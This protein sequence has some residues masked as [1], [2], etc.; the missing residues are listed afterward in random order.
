MLSGSHRFFLP[1]R[2]AAG[3]ASSVLLMHL[4]PGWLVEGSSADGSVAS[5]PP[6]WQQALSTFEVGKGSNG[7]CWFTRDEDAGLRLLEAVGIHR[8]IQWRSVP[9]SLSFTVGVW[10]GGLLEAVAT[11]MSGTYSGHPF[12]SMNDIQYGCEIERYTSARGE[13][14][15]V[16]QRRSEGSEGP[17]LT[18]Y[19][20][21]RPP[22]SDA[23]APVDD[24]DP[25]EWT[26]VERVVF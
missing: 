14:L 5:L 26:R 25:S 7:P 3:D 21:H 10:G 16:V 12:H 23:W 15:R 1:G 2:I 13:A 8:W 17:L 18:V 11:V 9:K 6:V 19:W 20:H 22:Q 4:S 24:L